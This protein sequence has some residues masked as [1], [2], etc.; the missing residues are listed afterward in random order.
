MM[1]KRIIGGI[2]AGAAAVLMLSGF[3]SAMTVPE[4]QEKMKSA[5]AEVNSVSAVIT[6]RASS[7]LEISQGGED[8]DSM[9]IPIDGNFNFHYKMNLDPLQMEADISYD[10]DA[11]GQ[12]MRGD[13]GVYI[14]ENE[15]GTGDAFLGKRSD[16][17][18]IEWDWETVDPESLGKLK[19]AIRSYVSSDVSTLETTIPEGGDNIDTEAMKALIEKYQDEFSGMM[20]IAPQSVTD[21]DKEY[22]LLTADVRGDVLSQVITDVMALSGQSMDDMSLQAVSAFLS[23][24][25]MHLESEVDTQTYLPRNVR[26]DF[27]ESD[28]SAIA[29][30]ILESAMGPQ[31]GAQA[32]LDVSA[33]ELEGRFNYDTPITVVVPQPALEATG[34]G[35]TAGP[36]AGLQTE[37]TDDLSPEDLIGGLLTGG[38]DGG[39]VTVTGGEDGT[40]DTVTGTEDVDTQDGPIQNADGTYHLRYEDYLGNVTEADVACPA[41]LKLSYGTPE[42]ISFTNDDYSLDVSYNLY[43]ADTPQETVENDLD[44]SFMKENSDFTDVN[45]TGVFQTALADGTEVFFGHKSYTYDDYRLGGTECAVQAGDAVVGIEIQREDDHRQVV[46][47]SEEDVKTFASCVKIP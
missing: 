9:D 37:G 22:Y 29:A 27:S 44:V 6:G 46:E 4:L 33:L 18:E 38:E 47:A 31:S 3:D 30:M 41:G 7:D 16:D 24:M 12:G 15:D 42:Y 13:M 5:L 11:M 25:V 17:G 26:I 14:L 10:A 36:T 40:D 1:R 32:V 43:S 20:Q 34:S 39:D 19:D 23:P 2:V 21:G 35:T 28:F 8:G 45:R